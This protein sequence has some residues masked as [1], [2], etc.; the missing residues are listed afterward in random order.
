MDPTAAEFADYV[1]GL[2]GEEVKAFHDLDFANMDDMR[3]VIQHDVDEP[4]TP[5]AAEPTVFS[6]A[7]QAPAFNC[8]TMQELPDLVLNEYCSLE[9]QITGE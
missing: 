8:G 3:C 2:S 5:P 6:M 4:F 9:S 7:F 1:P